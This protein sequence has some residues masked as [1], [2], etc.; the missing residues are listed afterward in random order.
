MKLAVIGHDDSRTK[1]V[2]R[3]GK[4][5]GFTIITPAKGANASN[6]AIAK[7]VGRADAVIYVLHES[8][9]IIDE[10]AHK[11]VKYLVQ[12]MH[13]HGVKRLVLFSF[14]QSEHL[15]DA[16]LKK[17]PW[18]TRIKS[19]FKHEAKTAVDLL[20]DSKLDWTIVGWQHSKGRLPN[21]VGKH[22]ISQLT[23]VT[24]LR[25]VF[26]LPGSD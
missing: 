1:D 10:S 6:G 18:L 13:K 8:C 24:N 5:T 2:V 25:R 3:H 23:D 20:R 16:K 12:A 7:V 9:K 11:G 4:K 17:T 21:D 26:M 19:F 15:E 22:M 14:I